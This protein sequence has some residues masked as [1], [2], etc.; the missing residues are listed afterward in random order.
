MIAWFEGCSFHSRVGH[1]LSTVTY[2]MFAKWA[3]EFVV[4]NK[5]LLIVQ[6]VVKPLPLIFNVVQLFL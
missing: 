5:D 1:P 4:Y 6:H 3:K 2:K